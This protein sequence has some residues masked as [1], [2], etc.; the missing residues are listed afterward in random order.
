V[1]SRCAGASDADRVRRQQDRIR[2]PP[3]II[4][5]VVGLVVAFVLATENLDAELFLRDGRIDFRTLVGKFG[6]SSASL[7]TGIALG[8]EGPSVGSM[9]A[10]VLGRRLALHLEPEQ[11]TN[12]AIWPR[13]GQPP[14]RWRLAPTEPARRRHSLDADGR[15]AIPTRVVG[16]RVGAFRRHPYLHPA[17]LP[18][19]MDSSL[20]A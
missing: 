3:P 18:F 15:R 16:G 11:R 13:P 7:A 20:R 1:A 19:V 4:G 6:L 8:P 9:I 2:L 17:E 5:A 10:S 12:S 14:R